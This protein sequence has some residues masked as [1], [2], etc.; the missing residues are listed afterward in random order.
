MI[1]FT[2]GA[3]SALARGIDVACGCFGSASGTIT[4]A[5][6]VRDLALLAAAGVVLAF[7]GRHDRRAAAPRPQ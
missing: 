1:V 3:S 4:W 7:D 5:T 6:V 2:V